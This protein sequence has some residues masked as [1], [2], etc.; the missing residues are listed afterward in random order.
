[1]VKLLDDAA[2][3]FLQPAAAPSNEPKQYGPEWKPGYGTAYQDG[4]DN[5]WAPGYGTDQSTDDNPF[6]RTDNKPQANGGG[7]VWSPVYYDAW[8]G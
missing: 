7:N 3:D 1:M 6:E 4:G 5:V 8:F 2:F